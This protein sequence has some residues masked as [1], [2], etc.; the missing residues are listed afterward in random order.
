[1]TTILSSLPWFGG[2]AET[3]NDGRKAVASRAAR[4]AHLDPDATLATF[5]TTRAGLVT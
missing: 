2:K 1:M 3:G 4:D 5:E